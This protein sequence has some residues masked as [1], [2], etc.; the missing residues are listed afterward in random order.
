MEC[1]TFGSEALGTQGTTIIDARHGDVSRVAGNLNRVILNDVLF[2]NSLTTL[3]QLGL[4]A[5]VTIEISLGQE[6]I[7]A[8]HV[9]S[10]LGS[11]NRQ[12]IV[13]IFVLLSLSG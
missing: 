6:T 12:L 10:H 7:V 13:H 2:K 8:G 3:V 1:L 9:L 11:S 5:G 4:F